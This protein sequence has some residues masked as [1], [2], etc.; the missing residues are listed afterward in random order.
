MSIYKE[1]SLSFHDR[2]AR[3][4][5]DEELLKEAGF[6]GAAGRV[7][8]GLAAPIVGVARGAKAAGTGLKTRLGHEA[9]YLERR[10]K[11]HLAHAEK[12]SKAK[13]AAGEKM[14]KA[15]LDAKLKLQSAKQA[16]KLKRI[17]AGKSGFGYQAK[18]FGGA[19]GRGVGSI[20]RRREPVKQGMSLGT[21]AAIGAAGAAGAGGLY[22]AGRGSGRRAA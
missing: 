1:A 7:G 6:W 2:L 16:A 4:D 13:L 15:K 9:A 18:R 8:K 12:T 10:G 5:F 21:K 3:G 17:K 20:F 11:A 22:M 19:I 14:T